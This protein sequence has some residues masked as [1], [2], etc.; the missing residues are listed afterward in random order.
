M[1][2]AVVSWTESEAVIQLI[3]EV[4][5]EQGTEI[6]IDCEIGPHCLLATE[7]RRKIATV[8]LQIITTKSCKNVN[9]FWGRKTYETSKLIVKI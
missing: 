3:Y 4:Q 1:P 9:Q 7:E 6:N 2:R 8:A 5:I